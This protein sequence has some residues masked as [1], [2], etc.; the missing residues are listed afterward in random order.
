MICGQRFSAFN[1]K[2]HC[3]QCGRVVCS[4]CSPHR[5]IIDPQTDNKPERGCSECVKEVSP[6]K[7]K[8]GLCLALL[9]RVWESFNCVLSSCDVLYI[10]SHGLLVYMCV[11]VCV[12]VAGSPE[13]HAKAPPGRL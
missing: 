4:S 2:H 9:G 10:H 7:S 5:V 1:R 6:V 3:R 12:C 8:G 13:L 11:C